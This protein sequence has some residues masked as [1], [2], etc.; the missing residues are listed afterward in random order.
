MGRD[1][2]MYG[3]VVSAPI[4]ALRARLGGPAWE[5]AA[6]LWRELGADQAVTIALELAAGEG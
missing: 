1:S 6:G 4:D 3:G 5:R 2:L